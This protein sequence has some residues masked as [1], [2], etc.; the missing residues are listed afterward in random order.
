MSVIHINNF[1]KNIKLQLFAAK[2]M[3]IT[4][5]VWYLVIIIVI[6]EY[7]FIKKSNIWL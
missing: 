7:S 3:Q 2:F 5:I 4:I 6:F 1:D